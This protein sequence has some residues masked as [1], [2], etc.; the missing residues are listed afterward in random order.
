MVVADS[1]I[2]S[3]GEGGILLI[4]KEVGITSYDVIRRI[5]GELGKGVK[6]GHA[7]TLD[8]F[9]SGLLV[10]LLGKATKSMNMFHAMTKRYCFTLE[11]GYETDTLDPTGEVVERGAIPTDLTEERIQAILKEFI[12]K[13]EQKPPIFSAKKIKGKKAYELARK[14]LKPDLKPK[15]VEIS[16][17]RLISIEGSILSL[18]AEVSSGTY[19][20]QLAADIGRSFGSFATTIDLRRTQIGKY[21][22]TDAID[23]TKFSLGAIFDNLLEIPR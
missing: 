16:V 9:A 12:G 1:N 7:G 19:I 21:G 17:L 5:K 18:E 8:P 11:L 4:D 10:I 15:L 20:R 23:S 14:G 22:V 13:I 3:I 2:S 6:I